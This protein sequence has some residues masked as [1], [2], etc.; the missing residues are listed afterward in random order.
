MME[1]GSFLERRRQQIVYVLSHG[2]QY[3]CLLQCM[4]TDQRRGWGGPFLHA[5]KMPI[6]AFL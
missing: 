6:L 1:G 2:Q 4:K 3:D 5:I